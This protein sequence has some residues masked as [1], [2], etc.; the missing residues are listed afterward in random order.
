MPNGGDNAMAS[1]SK[2][3]SPK[4]KEK[5]KV[6]VEQDSSKKVPNIWVMNPSYKDVNPKVSV[7]RLIVLGIITLFFVITIYLFTF[8]LVLGIG[9]GI[10]FLVIFILVFYDVSFYFSA[11]FQNL[12]VTDPFRDIVFFTHREVSSTLYL[13]NKKEL[14]TTGIKIFKVEIIPENVSPAVNMF[15]KGLNEYKNRISFTYQIIQ[16]PMILNGTPKDQIRTCIYFCVYSSLNGNLNVTKIE[17]LY[18]TIEGGA[19]VLKSNFTGN[20][21][22]FKIVLL[23]GNQLIDAVRSYI[24][25]TSV[26]NNGQP[27]SNEKFSLSPSFIL[28]FMFLAFIVMLSSS[29]LLLIGVNVLYIL[30]SNALLV[31]VVLYLWWRD[32]FS[33]TSKIRLQKSGSIIVIQPFNDTI[34]FRCQGISDSL[35]ASVNNTLLIGIKM[36]NLA[37][38]FPP[39]FCMVPKFIQGIMNQKVSFA[40]TCINKPVSYATFYKKSID[41]LNPKTRFDLLTS[42]FRLQTR[43]DE[44]NWLAMRAGIWN[45]IFTLSVSE[46]ESTNSLSLEQ[47]HALEERMNLKAQIL[48]NS[49]NINFFNYELI[50][51]RTQK[52]LAGL[53][54][55]LIKTNEYTWEGTKLNYVMF[56]GKALIHLTE[57]A[58]ELKKGITTRIA[59]EFNTPLYLDNSILIGTTINTE[60]LEEEMPFGFTKDQLHTILTVNG[61]TLSRELFSMKLV[62]ELVKA[63]MPSLIFD[64]KGTWSRIIALCKGTPFEHEFLHFKLGSAFSLDPVKS[65]IPYDK[66]NVN[67]LNLMFDAYALSFKRDQ[68]TVDA[69]RTT[70]LQ[71]PELDMSSLNMML[72]NQNQWEKAPGTGNLLS[73]FGDFTQQD[74]QYLHISSLNPSEKITFQNFIQDDKTVIIDLSIT[75][76]FR[77]QIF[78]TF[79]II[80]KILHYLSHPAKSFVPKKLIIPHIDLFFDSYYLDRNADYGKINKF[81]DPLLERGFGFIFS[82]NQAHYLH[83]NLITYFENI[84]AFKATDS[85]DIS[86]L[87]NSMNLTELHGTGIYSKSRNELYQIQYLMSMRPNEAIVKRVDMYQPFPVRFDWREITNHESLPLEEIVKYM[88]EQGFDLQDSERKIL[89]QVK[90]SLFEKDFGRYANFI[91]EIKQFLEAL[92]TIDQIG[93]LY[94]KK[95][96]KELKTILYPKASK[97]FKTKVEIKNVRDDIFNL[98]VKHGYIVENHPRTASGSES[99]RTSYSVGEQYQKALDDEFMLSRPYIVE[100]LERESSLP[101]QIPEQKPQKR[102][103][104]QERDLKKAIAREFSNF[105]F[106]LFTVYEYINQ[107]KFE[108]AMKIEFNLVSRFFS[109]VYNHYYNKAGLV[110]S[111]ELDTF[112]E[113]LVN[114]QSI[115][116]TREEL[117]TYLL[118]SQ[119]SED[120]ENTTREWYNHIS[121]FFDKIQSYICPNEGFR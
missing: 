12:I 62:L 26:S 68:R 70:I 8:N 118:L 64:F 96:K 55:E 119:R 90:K 103:K 109:E 121:T 4:P 61:T 29:L 93:N 99:I 78:L 45:T 106:E 101:F 84:V 6:T 95:I 97:F 80:S 67:F 44:I 32:I 31:I 92:Q 54:T 14:V 16:T 36:F 34:F 57:I 85:R 79:L 83:P 11:V 2:K 111:Q 77:K 94:E 73:L 53:A 5:L 113:G 102:F 81:I 114:T 30:L 115:P 50:Q 74:E 10:G 49:F 47:I 43:L 39:F 33:S 65:D 41:Y 17:K 105:L 66:D 9:V 75:N 108:E 48:H 112:L 46:F 56:Q 42:Q 52:L 71:N 82:A 15:I 117:H 7:A 88:S 86:A 51:L 38:A 120:I 25:R 28:K 76:D 98:L 3:A 91:D 60:M 100:T 35:F 24:F 23:S 87:S 89:D 27:V 116:F 37:G 63:K 21:H 18:K 1:Y 72:L 59:S 22:H 69:M 104:I 13:F 58:G 110:S 107:G 20:Y 19:A 40:Y